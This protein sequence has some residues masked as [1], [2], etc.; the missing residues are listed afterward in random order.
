MADLNPYKPPT[1]ESGPA[2][3]LA[4]T[5]KRLLIIGLPALAIAIAIVNASVIA[6]AMSNQTDRDGFGD[7]VILLSPVVALLLCLALAIAT[8]RA[9]RIRS[10]LGGATAR[11][12]FAGCF[13]FLLLQMSMVV[14]RYSLISSDG[15]AY[16]GIVFLPVVW[17]WLPLLLLGA[18]VGFAM[19]ALTGHPPHT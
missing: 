18:V 19:A 3:T 6:A 11:G 8:L 7:W 4:R 2:A 12:A 5:A 13:L 16:W 15:T 17:L 10:R 14:P 9:D 1:V